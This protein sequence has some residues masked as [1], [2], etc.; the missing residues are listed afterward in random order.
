MTTESVES[1]AM[2][3]KML[4]AGGGDFLLGVHVEALRQVMEAEVSAALGAEGMGRSEVSPMATVLE[5]Q[6]RASRTRPLADRTW[7]YLW[8]DAL[9]LKLHEGG[10]VVSAAVL[11]ARRAFRAG[12]V[13]RGLSGTLLVISDVHPGL[14]AGIRSVR[15]G[16]TW[17]R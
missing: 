6:I 11:V 15:D 8:L 7:L 17:Q 16:V 9:Y 3:G 13:A 4:T 1:Q 2:L 14:R 5:G 12:L 10:R